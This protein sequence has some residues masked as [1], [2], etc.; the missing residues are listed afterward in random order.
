MVISFLFLSVWLVENSPHNAKNVMVT[1]IAG[2][3]TLHNHLKVSIKRKNASQS[4]SGPEKRIRK[5]QPGPNKK[6][7]DEMRT[8]KD[9]TVVHEWGGVME[10]RNLC[11]CTHARAL[12]FTSTHWESKVV[13]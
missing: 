7:K 10:E 11:V 1:P 13:Y 2:E 8:C 4:F 6:N 3:T 12:F 5:F 9:K